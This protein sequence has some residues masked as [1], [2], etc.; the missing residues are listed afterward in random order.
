M[1]TSQLAM[2]RSLSRRGSAAI[3]ALV[4]LSLAGLTVAGM[5]RHFSNENIRFHEETDRVELEQLII[6]GTI[7]D[8][9]K[10]RT[11]LS[12]PDELIKRNATLTIEKTNDRNS[13]TATLNHRH[14]QWTTDATPH[15]PG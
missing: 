4:I 6:A 8:Q 3:I 10:P 5:M 2:Y 1:R 14:Q 12:L 11:K 9:V 7:D 15:P 13:I